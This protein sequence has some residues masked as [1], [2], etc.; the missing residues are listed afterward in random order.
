MKVVLVNVYGTIPALRYGGVER[1]MWWLGR[2]LSTRGHEVTYLVR[3]GS[4]PFARVIQHDPRRPLEPQIPVD[5]DVVHVQHV[6]PDGESIARP[7]LITLHGPGSREVELDRDTVFVSRDHA[8]RFGSTCFVHNGIDWDGY[9][10][11]SLDAPRAW[12]HFLGDGAWKVKNLR[13]AIRVASLAGEELRVAG[14]FRLN[15][16]MGFRLTMSP[17]VKFHG[18]VGEEEKRRILSGSKGLLFPVRWREPF[19]LAIVESLYFGCPVFGTPYGSLPELV[20]PGVGFLSADA[21]ELAEA[22][23]GAVRFD[24]RRCHAHAVS[25]F[26]VGTMTDR[27]LEVYERVRSGEHLHDAPPR[28]TQPPDQGLLPFG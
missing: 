1:V 21:G 2:E 16:R 8:A 12:V 6:L 24:R 22:V 9:G 11:P 4:C 17:R 14:G 25:G 7:R 28:R 3:G 10:P 23:R 19:G 13:G 27:Y 26:G 20:P 5:T 18:W 15:F